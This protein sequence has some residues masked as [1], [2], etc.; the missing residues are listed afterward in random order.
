MGVATAAESGDLSFLPPN[1]RRMKPPPPASPPDGDSE[2]A[3]A[4]A[5]GGGD[6]GGALA[7]GVRV[8]VEVGITAGAGEAIL[9]YRVY[10]MVRRLLLENVAFHSQNLV[11]EL[12]TS[13][14]NFSPRSGAAILNH[15][16]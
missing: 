13:N 5:V 6:V 3:G 15:P 10:P 12:M 9:I 4:P 16:Q 11:P 14:F 1:K 2:A 8:G 7:S